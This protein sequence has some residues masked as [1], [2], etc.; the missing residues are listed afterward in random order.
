L[1]FSTMSHNMLYWMSEDEF[2]I[3]ENTVFLSVIKNVHYTCV[4]KNFSVRSL[5]EF[6]KIKNVRESDGGLLYS[7]SAIAYMTS[8]W[9]LKIY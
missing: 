6:S 7:F 9:K 2:S 3:V 1:P 5:C 4:L 8:K